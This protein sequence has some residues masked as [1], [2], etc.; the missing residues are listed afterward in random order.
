MLPVSVLL[1]LG[2]DTISTALPD[3]IPECTSG[4][5]TEEEV[6]SCSH[7]QTLVKTCDACQLSNHVRSFREVSR[8]CCFC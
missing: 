2:G 3:V 4:A 8:G 7:K 6:S 5:S 1:M